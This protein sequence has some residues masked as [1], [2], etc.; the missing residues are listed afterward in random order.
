MTSYAAL[1]AAGGAPVELY[2]FSVGST[3]YTYT[4][5]SEEYTYQDALASA[6]ETYTPATVNRDQSLVSP[7]SS[8]QE[9]RVGLGVQNPVAQLF[10]NGAAPSIVTCV[11]V[12]FHRGADLTDPT[13]FVRWVGLVAGQQWQGGE[14]RISVTPPQRVIQQ[15]IPRRRLQVLCNH[16]LYDIACTITKSS[17]RLAGTVASIS[18][19]RLTIG[20]TLGATAAVP[21]YYTLGILE[22][23]QFNGFIETHVSS[24]GTLATVTLLVPIASLAVSA[25]VNLLPGCDRSY[26]TCI[27]K[28][29]NGI[30]HGGFPYIVNSDPWANGVPLIQPADTK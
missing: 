9:L 26:P 19:D 22:F 17:K 2:R 30:N 14:V 25:S 21:S 18:S 8:Q 4:S 29:A 12:R 5:D 15:K 3:A 7:E 11:V 10:I 1:E 16:N 6:P 24:S 13:Q 27:N 28:F 20:V 23:G